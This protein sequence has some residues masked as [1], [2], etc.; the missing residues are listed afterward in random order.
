ML[1]GP[2]RKVEFGIG[3]EFPPLGERLRIAALSRPLRPQIA[4]II[5]AIDFVIIF[6]T[7]GI[8]CEV[9]NP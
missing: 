9:R 5:P 7:K 3:C 2:F 4:R 1:A 8:L 6:R